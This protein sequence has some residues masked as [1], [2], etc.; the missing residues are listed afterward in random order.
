MPLLQAAFAFLLLVAALPGAALAAPADAYPRIVERTITAFIRPGYDRLAA[1][2]KAMDEAASALCSAPSMATLTAARGQFAKVVDAWSRVELL[3]FGPVREDN[4]YERL[5]FWP[6]RRSLGL[7][8]VQ[9]IISAKDESAIGADALWDKSVA[10]QGLGALE[11]TLFGTGA[12]KLAE[13][14]A[15]DFRCRYAE[16][17]AARMAATAGDISAEWKAADGFSAVLLK[18]GDDNPVYRTSG[19]VVQDFLRAM[20]EE[21]QFVRDLKIVAVMGEDAKDANPRVA[22]FRRAGLTVAAI[23]ANVDSVLA[24][25]EKGDFISA[26]GEEDAWLSQ[27]LRFEVGQV[28]QSLGQVEGD[29]GKALRDKEKRKFLEL[30]LISLHGAKE[31]IGDYYAGRTGLA[32]GFNSFDGD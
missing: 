30:V 9:R 29:F 13:K 12:D 21:M 11:F 7:R 15:A 3:R 23:K 28:F 24:M 22:P 19:E 17:I 10:V 32:I 4:R 25:F 20:T 18:P 14:G 27:S 26:L 31:S 8:Q 5:N 1:E 6:D 2:A 16:S